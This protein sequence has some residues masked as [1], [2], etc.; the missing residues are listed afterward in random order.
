M[1]TAEMIESKYLKKEDVGEDGVI[2][3]IAGFD[4]VNVARDDEAAEYKYTMRFEEFS[5]PMVLNATNIQ[6]TE[7]ALGSNDTDDWIGK[8]IIV[9][10]EPNISFGNKLVGG[11]RIR[12]H[13]KSAGPRQMQRPAQRGSVDD[14]NRK[15][16]AASQRSDDDVDF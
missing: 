16:D 14:V 6:L 1:K 8:Q 4:K 7:K 15:L 2:V 3:T 11:I 9:Y 13:R 10:N 12:A 5:K